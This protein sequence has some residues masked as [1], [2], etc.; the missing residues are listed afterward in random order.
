M[1]AMASP[2]ERE[3]PSIARRTPIRRKV[4]APA[5]ASDSSL[6]RIQSAS[7]DIS[8][9][10]SSGEGAVI[11]RCDRAVIDDHYWMA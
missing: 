10:A 8:F 5:R 2:G 1:E 6:T 7:M 11:P 3:A 4:H 9:P